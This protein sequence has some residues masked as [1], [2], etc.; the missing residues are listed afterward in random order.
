VIVTPS[1]KLVGSDDTVCAR[2]ILM[3]TGCPGGQAI[4]KERADV[5]IE[6]KPEAE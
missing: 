4:G 2:R 3:M 5:S 6:V 1:D